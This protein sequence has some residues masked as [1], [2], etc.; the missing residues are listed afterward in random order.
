MSDEQQNATSNTTNEPWTYER[1]R[2][3][4]RALRRVRYTC[5]DIATDVGA[6]MADPEDFM[7]VW[8]LYREQ[9]KRS[10]SGAP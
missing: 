9:Q 2:K 3:V 1:A 6:D 8:S 5:D 10:D 4:Y 7:A